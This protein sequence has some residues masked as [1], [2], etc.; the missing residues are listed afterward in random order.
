MQTEK[1]LED[2]TVEEVIEWIEQLELTAKE[3]VKEKVRENGANGIALCSCNKVDDVGDIDIPTMSRPSLFDS[4]LARKQSEKARENLKKQPDTTIKIEY[5]VT[6][7]LKSKNEIITRCHEN[8]AVWE[9]KQRIFEETNVSRDALQ[10]FI[11]SQEITNENEPIKTYGIKPRCA[12]VSAFLRVAGGSQNY[13]IRK[14]NKND[15][16]IKITKE[17]DCITLDD[18]DEY[19]RAL[20]SCGHAIGPY[21]MFQ[22]VESSLEKNLSVYQ[23]KCPAVIKDNPITTCGAVW[24]WQLVVAIADMSEEEY[25]RFTKIINSRF[26]E[27]QGIRECP[28]CLGKCFRDKNLT[29]FRARCLGCKKADFCWACGKL[30]KGSGVQIC[31]N[32]ECPILRTNSVLSTCDEKPLVANDVKT[33]TLIP[34]V[35]AC[36]NCLTLISHKERCKHMTCGGCGK[37]FCFFCLDILQ[38]QWKCGGAYEPCPKGIAPRQILK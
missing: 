22:F 20:M 24:D 38:D 14:L 23:I 9:F 17:K 3:K 34:Q 19:P 16:K 33:N 32:E 21:S 8:M 13:R 30:W 15:S 4:I 12:L 1:K 2:L 27:A 18:I 7:S 35:R 37:N 29:I 10:L 11:H 25:M 28:S 36:P 31:G 26:E 5:S 6:V